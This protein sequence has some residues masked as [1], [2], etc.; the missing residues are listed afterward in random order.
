[1]KRF[2]TCLLALALYFAARAFAQTAAPLAIVDVNVVDVTK[3][4]IR[5]HQSVVIAGNRIIA[6]G[7]SDAVS[8]PTQAIRIPGEGRY[9]IPGL[10]DMH[11]H[12][13]SSVARP[14]VPL[15]EENAALLDL[16]LPN[17]VVGVREMGGDL[18]DSVF[19][20]REEIRSGKR[21]GPAS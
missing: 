3:G 16:F 13:R 20:W 17:G 12:L 18:A 4:E 8:V 6:V 19:R 9:L 21:I 2:S 7:S 5:G 14:D 15:V 10:W 11:I 1:M